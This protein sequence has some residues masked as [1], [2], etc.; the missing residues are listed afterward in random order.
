MFRV[1]PM[2]TLGLIFFTVLIQKSEKQWKG[3][4]DCVQ[5]CPQ[6]IRLSHWASPLGKVWW[7]SGIPEDKFFQTTTVDFPLF[8]PDTWHSTVPLSHTS[9]YSLHPPC[10]ATIHTPIP[11]P[12]HLPTHTPSHRTAQLHLHTHLNTH[13][14]THLPLHTPTHFPS[15]HPTHHSLETPDQ[16]IGI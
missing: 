2:A 1:K 3:L 5:N 14:P 11:T 7:P 13:T 8:I 6:V 10:L 15:H 16:Y 4:S 12:V 9:N